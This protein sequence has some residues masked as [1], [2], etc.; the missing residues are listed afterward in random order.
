M[1]GINNLSFT[2]P[3]RPHKTLD[4]INMVIDEG[5]LFGLLGPNGAGK[6]TLISILSGLLPCSSGNITINGKE[7]AGLNRLNKPVCALVP[8]SLAFYPKLTG[9][10]NLEFFAAILGM[11]P[12]AVKSEVARCLSLT[13]LDSYAD[14]RS[15][16]YSGGV[17][18]RLNIAIGLLNSPSILFLDEPTV[19]IDAQSRNFILESI[20]DINSAGTTII[21]T[22][23]YMEEVEYL[24][25]KIAIIDH[26]KIL[27]QGSLKDILAKQ[28]IL[29][30]HSQ[31]PLTEANLEE[32]RR[33]DLIVSQHLHV[34]DIAI[35]NNQHLISKTLALLS[36]MNIGIE[37]ISYGTQH[38]EQLFLDKT[39]RQLRE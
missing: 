31:T 16:T 34:L 29:S 13:Q 4:N 28:Q 5:C 33:H 18:R 10:E 20:K 36:T 19:G 8:Q 30:I 11:S 6:T 35:D 32:L 2:Y 12:T 3:D 22:S 38:L 25:E 21:Y 26:G 39:D 24:C 37:K 23:H 27:L 14:I 7:L 17:K 1:I 15:S 9:K